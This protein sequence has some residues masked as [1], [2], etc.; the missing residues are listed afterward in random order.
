MIRE[1]LIWYVMI[2]VTMLIN[3]YQLDPVGRDVQ[4]NISH[5]GNYV[6][7]AAEKGRKGM[8]CLA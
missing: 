5:D 3:C 7:L 4:F 2:L 8:F 6:V 1:S